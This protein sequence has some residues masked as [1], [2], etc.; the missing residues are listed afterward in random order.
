MKIAVLVYA[1]KE[2]GL[3]HWN[4]SV[5]LIK[6]LESRGHMVWVLGNM[7][8]HRKMYF[9]VREN[10]EI[11]LYHVIEQLKPDVLIADLQTEVPKYVYEIIG[12]H[13]KLVVLN[14]VG[15]YMDSDAGMLFIQGLGESTDGHIFA[16]PEYVILRPEL[17]KWYE[18]PES[19]WFVFGGAK[20]K[21]NLSSTFQN[22]FQ[23]TNTNIL[24]TPMSVSLDHTYRTMYHN[25]FIAPSIDKQVETLKMAVSNVSRACIAMGMTAWEMAALG[26]P[27]YAF[28]A[29]QGHL[30]FARRMEDAGILRAWNGVGLPEE[31]LDFKEFLELPPIQPKLRPD[32]MGA[33]RVADRLEERY[34]SKK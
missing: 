11:D 2:V 10:S 24:M 4:R 1:H 23:E 27:T 16:G 14:G 21:M 28:S 15:R 26:I 12:D 19:E 34:G 9:Q 22:V 20:D 18:G 33:S 3:G 5:A 6:E 29:T 8:V 30:D 17:E 7:M 25:I 13:E 32:F 31:P